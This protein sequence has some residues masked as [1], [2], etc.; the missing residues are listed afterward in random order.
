MSEDQIEY[1]I[2]VRRFHPVYPEVYVL[3]NRDLSEL[4]SLSAVVL[5][6]GE[7]AALG[8]RSAGKM[9]GTVKRY[10]GPI[11]VLVPRD[12]APKI[13]GIDASKATFGLYEVGTVHGIATTTLARTYFDLAKVLD[14]KEMVRAF[15][16][17]RKRGLTINQM[18]RLLE[19]HKGERGTRLVREVLARQRTYDG[20][21]NGGFEDA[22]WE[23]L[24]SLRLP[25][26]PRRN[27]NVMLLDGTTRQ[28]DLLLRSQIVELDH[29]PHHGANRRQTTID[30][31]RD[32][33]L[34]A[35]GYDVDH[36]TSDEFLDELD[37]VEGDV[38]RV[39]RA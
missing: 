14:R 24:L 19:R 1:A 33:D 10:R 34:R 13:D 27:A 7:G 21:S 8:R 6:C 12:N 39:L 35:A 4:G 31:Q 11:E 38:R 17:S 32:R 20:F 2:K 5:A 23:W 28:V 30:A 15:E 36:F 26:L 25:E 18:E 16:E 9:R 22:F 3:G 37:R 29:H